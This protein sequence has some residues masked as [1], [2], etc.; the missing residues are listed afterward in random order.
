MHIVGLGGSFRVPSTSLSALRVALRAA[1][2]DS[3]V[4]VDLLDLRTLDL[5]P[6]GSAGPCAGV[7]RLVRAAAAADAMIWSA[8]MYHGTVSGAFKNAVDWLDELA[9]LDPPFLTNRPV[10][11]IAT[12]A[13]AQ[14]LQAVNTMEFAVRALRG[15][16]VPFVV[17]V[18]AAQDAFRA[19]GTI[20]DRALAGRLS[21][22]GSMVAQGARCFAGT[23]APAV[24]G[25]A[26]QWT[27]GLA[28]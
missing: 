5:P 27:T 15:W 3:D 26:E 25:R 21:A 14:A 22:L 4:D 20:A 24:R 8:P 2:T 18:N 9:G 7:S 12:A 28:G 11:L 23:A 16:V 10:G 6:N 19:D 13:G 1:M 17:P